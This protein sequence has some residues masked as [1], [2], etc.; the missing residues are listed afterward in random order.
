[1]VRHGRTWRYKSTVISQEQSEG[2]EK[3]NDY[4][5]G[6][7][8]FPNIRRPA[9]GSVSTHKSHKHCFPSF[10]PA[11][12]SDRLSNVVKSTANVLGTYTFG[13]H[14]D[15]LLFAIDVTCAKPRR[16]VPPGP[17]HETLKNT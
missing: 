8:P 13:P 3:F 7:G 11:F 10:E 17:Y 2:I 4:I 14:A 1:M 15:S 6:A 5:K 16:K 12:P 9:R